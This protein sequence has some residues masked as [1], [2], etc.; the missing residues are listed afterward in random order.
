M[1]VL[2][3]FNP[4]TGIWE[5]IF[6]G[7]T[8]SAG[9]PGVGV[10]PGGTI[11]QVLGKT[12]SAD[13][14]TG[15]V[16]DQVGGDGGGGAGVTDG[17]K[18]DIIVSGAGTTW[19][20]DSTVVTS[21]ARTVLDDISTTAM[22]TTLGL[23]NVNNTADASKPLF[24][25]TVRGLTPPPTTLTGA[26]LK[27]DGTWTI[28]PSAASAVSGVFPFTYNTSTAESISGSQLRGNSGTFASSTKLWVSELTV[29]GLDVAVGLG[30]I[31]AGFQVYIQDFTSSSRFVVFN[32]T[33]DTIDKGNYWEITVAAASSAG[34]IPGGKIALQSLSSAQ[35]SKLFST[36]T[37]APGLT[38][39]SSGAGATAYLNAT[40][41]WSV[42]AGGGGGGSLP[43]GGT[44]GQVLTKTS[45]ADGA[46]NWSNPSVTNVQ[47]VTGLWSGTQ[48]AYDA[49]VSK[50]PTTLYFI[51]G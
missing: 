22:R 12:G 42:P 13:Y 40:G 47:G 19:S 17:D 27:D 21:V 5:P 39:G 20:L 32:V 24:T 7:G 4:T 1:T 28:P 30:R 36:T 25:Q 16:A 26:Y 31:K 9:P 44:T 50:S 33:A 8:G 3:Q 11:G 14:A 46:A 45:A 35:A 29:D 23:G 48:A 34:T 49:I 2:K 38:P 43:S 6:T 37:T 41:T 10:P 15:W 18:G 51:S